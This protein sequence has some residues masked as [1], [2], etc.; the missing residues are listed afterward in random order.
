MMK[1]IQDS[2]E[3]FTIKFK[4]GKEES[5]VTKHRSITESKKAREA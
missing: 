4:D 2:L 1:L 5:S 3:V